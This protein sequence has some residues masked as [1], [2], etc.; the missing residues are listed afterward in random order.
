MNPSS[1]A[2]VYTGRLV[3]PQAA[4]GASDSADQSGHRVLPFL[5]LF[6][7][8]VCQKDLIVLGDTESPHLETVKDFNGLLGSNGLI[9]DGADIEFIV[10]TNVLSNHGFGKGHKVGSLA[11]SIDPCACV[12]ANIPLFGNLDDILIGIRLRIR[13]LDIGGI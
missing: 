5:L 7:L 2:L 3:G 10:D 13:P 9:V 12:A 1:R 8:P 11:E 4:P 6:V